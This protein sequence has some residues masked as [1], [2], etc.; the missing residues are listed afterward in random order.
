MYIP[1]QRETCQ[2]QDGLRIFIA[3]RSGRSGGANGL[4]QYL[5]TGK[6][7]VGGGGGRDSPAVTQ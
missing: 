7:A 3:F 4:G 5:A 2:G 1:Y 6:G